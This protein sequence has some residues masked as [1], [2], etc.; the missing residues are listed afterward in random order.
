MK[1]FLLELAKILFTVSFFLAFAGGTT[2]L[3][4]HETVPNWVA[5]V[6]FPWCFICMAYMNYLMKTDQI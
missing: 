3:F 5:Y 6:S 2:F 1:I 4:F